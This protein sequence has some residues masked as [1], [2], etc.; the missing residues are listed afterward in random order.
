MNIG[1]TLFEILEYNYSNDSGIVE[2]TIALNSGSDVFKGHFPQT[3][4]LPGVSML[5]MIKILVEKSLNE[6][7]ILKSASNIKYLSLVQ[8]DGENIH[9]ALSLKANDDNT[10]SVTNTLVKGTVVCMKFSGTY[11]KK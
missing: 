3:P 10:W 11:Q 7:L 1:N 9:F 6:K 4:V 8:P 2:A 5:Q